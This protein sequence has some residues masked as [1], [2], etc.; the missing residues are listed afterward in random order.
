MSPPNNDANWDRWQGVVETK[1]DQVLIAVRDLGGKFESHETEDNERFKEINERHS[2]LDSKVNWW[3][4]AAAAIGASIGYAISYVT[5]K[6][7]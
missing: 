6:P 5:G 4:G 7:Q 3:S 2:A 1:L